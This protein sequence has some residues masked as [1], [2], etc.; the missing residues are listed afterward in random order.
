MSF[1]LDALKKSDKK[2]QENSVP[3]LDV[4]HEPLP[5]K[6]RRMPFWFLLLVLL[7]NIGLLLWFLLPWR[8][9]PTPDSLA[10]V[11]KNQ[12]VADAV[13]VTARPTVTPQPQIPHYTPAHGITSPAASKP[14]LRQAA[15]NVDPRIYALA[16]LPTAVRRR[17]PALHMSLHA[18]NNSDGAASLVRINDQLLREGELLANTYLLEQITAA[19]AVFIYDGYRFLLPR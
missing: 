8:Q 6:S 7:L 10:A 3:R 4:V 17:I 1:I 12:P 14:L 16:E 15:A 18:Y 13:P 19:G 9:T 2:R 11:I 5:A